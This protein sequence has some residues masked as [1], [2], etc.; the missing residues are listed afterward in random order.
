[1]DVECG[2]VKSVERVGPHLT[3][4][5]RM[6]KKFLCPNYFRQLKVRNNSMKQT[7]WCEKLLYED[8]LTFPTDKADGNLGKCT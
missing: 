2:G 6:T 3:P 4:T 5:F 8:H 1:M 7:Q